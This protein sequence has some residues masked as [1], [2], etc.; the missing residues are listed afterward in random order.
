MQGKWD[1]ARLHSD[2][3]NLE[4]KIEGNGCPRILGQVPLEDVC[5][6]SDQAL[7]TVITD[8][9]DANYLQA[10]RRETAQPL[11]AWQG[12]I[13]YDEPQGPHKVFERHLELS[14]SKDRDAV[15]FIVF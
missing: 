10:K 15:P 14:A 3:G 5:K 13:H 7:D 8:G 9:V 11:Q 12:A 4:V 6:L 1:P 2:R